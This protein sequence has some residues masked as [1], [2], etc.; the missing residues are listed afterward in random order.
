MHNIKIRCQLL[1]AT[2]PFLWE[3]GLFLLITIV[4]HNLWWYFASEIK[5]FNVILQCSDILAHLVHQASFWVVE[6]VFRLLINE[7]G[8]HTI[9]FSNGKAL[10]VAESCSGLKQFFQVGVLFLVYPGTWIHKLWYIPL[11]FIVIHLTN[12]L[13]VVALSLWMAYDIPFWDFAHDWL[14][15]PSYYVVIFALWYFWNNRYNTK[16]HWFKRN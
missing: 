16:P 15:R 9:H 3:I 6:N 5:S 4:F 2:Y 11:S 14:M 10:V 8:I 13:R 1:L 12:I 7:E